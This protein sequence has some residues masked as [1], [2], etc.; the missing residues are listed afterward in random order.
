[1]EEKQ[2]TQESGLAGQMAK[3][4]L[5]TQAPPQT[6]SE[7]EIQ[8]LAGEYDL[9]KKALAR[10]KSNEEKLKEIH[11][12]GD[13]EDPVEEIMRKMAKAKSYFEE[14][15]K[16]IKRLEGELEAARN[17]RSTVYTEYSNLK[18]QF[19]RLSDLAK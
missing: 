6:K 19:G 1:M 17:Y 13:E 9:N 18:A 5:G 3:S 2:K 10:E 8:K 14:S 11:V 16:N 15:E 7:E 12:T 4:P